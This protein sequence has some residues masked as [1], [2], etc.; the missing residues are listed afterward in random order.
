M[1]FDNK[2]YICVMSE[3]QHITANPKR[4]TSMVHILPLSKLFN[5]DGQIEGLPKNPRYIKDHKFDK[6]VMSIEEDPELLLLKELWVV[7]YGDMYVIIAGNM[8]F[9]AAKT[10]GYTQLPCKVI[11]NHV[12]VD[13][14]RAFAMKDNIPYGEHNWEDLHNEWD[15]QELTH[16]GLDIEFPT[17]EEPEQQEPIERPVIKLEYSQDDYE[18]VKAQLSKINSSPEQAVWLLLGNK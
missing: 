3:L 12:S 14:L 4:D 2:V 18:V 6:L 9:R 5:N 10:L 7:P 17:T 16:W 1:F 15:A 8:R 13:K 11:P